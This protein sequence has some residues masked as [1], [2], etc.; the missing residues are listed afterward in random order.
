MWHTEVL[1]YSNMGFSDNGFRFYIHVKTNEYNNILH[2]LKIFSIM[3][4]IYKSKFLCYTLLFLQTTFDSSTDMFL[5]INE[6]RYLNS[7]NIIPII[8]SQ[9]NLGHGSTYRWYTTFTK[10]SFDIYSTWSNQH[11]C[12][13]PTF[14]Q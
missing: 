7:F 12:R 14:L 11:N 8:Q 5:I 2:N 6:L 10:R 4:I 1:N 13:A 3:C 9:K